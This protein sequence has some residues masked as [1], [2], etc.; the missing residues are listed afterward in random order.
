MEY[1]NNRT[2]GSIIIV[3]AVHLNYKRKISFLSKKLKTN[4]KQTENWKIAGFNTE[5]W[6]PIPSNFRT[7]A[8]RETGANR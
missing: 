8:S 4:W 3:K 5:S 6:F 1:Q 2:N 7:L